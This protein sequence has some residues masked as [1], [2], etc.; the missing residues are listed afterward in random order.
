MQ[1][2]FAVIQGDREKYLEAGM[3]DYL[4]KPIK[5]DDLLRAIQKIVTIH[6]EKN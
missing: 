6:P 1:H 5:V 3:D 4:A 2:L